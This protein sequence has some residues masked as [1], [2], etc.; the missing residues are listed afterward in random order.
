MNPQFNQKLL[1]A[2]ADN[3]ANII[4]KLFVMELIFIHNSLQFYGRVFPETI[5]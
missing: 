5:R 1:T 2:N 3:V 4:P